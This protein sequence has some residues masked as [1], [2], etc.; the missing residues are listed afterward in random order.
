MRDGK[1]PEIEDLPFVKRRRN[2]AGFHYW[3]VKP[4]GNYGQDCAIGNQLARLILPHLKYHGG[5]SLLGSI[6]VDMM[7][8]KQPEKHRG[9]IIG[10]MSEISINLSEARS[11]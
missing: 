8:T 11:Q 4:T 6:V 5:I 3:N 2:G 10:F 1:M 9:V 7:R